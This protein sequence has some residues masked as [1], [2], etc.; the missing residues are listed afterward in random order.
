VFTA[1]DADVFEVGQ[2]AEALVRSELDRPAGEREPDI[3]CALLHTDRKGNPIPCPGYAKPGEDPC[4]VHG[5][6]SPHDAH[7][8]S[9]GGWCP[10]L[11]EPDDGVTE[12]APPPTVTEQVRDLERIIQRVREAVSTDRPDIELA[13]QRRAFRA[14]LS[15]AFGLPNDEAI[16]V[17]S[18]ARELLD[19]A[20]NWARHGYEIGQ[21]HCGWSDHGVAPAWLTEDWPPHFDA[22]EH[23]AQ[24]G[25]YETALN[26]V[27]A[28]PEEPEVTSSQEPEASGFL[29]GY[30]VAIRSAKRAAAVSDQ[31]EE[32]R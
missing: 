16:D 28:L 15:E 10:G 29:R 11:S 26:R 25:E 30:G 14:R 4:Y 6:G 23:L 24:T 18:A 1:R 32:G 7:Q 2:A 21:R 31:P 13:A 22:C 3:S 20:R 5:L 17:I 12:P 9:D 8:R 19:E 27:R